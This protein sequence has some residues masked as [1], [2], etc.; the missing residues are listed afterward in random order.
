MNASFESA[1]DRNVLTMERM[2]AH[3]PGKVWRAVTET[4]H[5]AQWFPSRVEMD[6]RPG[7]EVRFDF[8]DGE[9]PESKGV[10]LEYDPPRALSFTWFEDT[11][12]FE[13][14]PDGDGCRLVLTHT[15]G[16]RAGAASFA[17]GWHVCLDALTT[18]LAGREVPADSP[19][20]ALHDDYLHRFGLDAG[21]VEETADGWRVRF[22]RQL[23]A[24][25]D[26][27]WQWLGAT[28]SDAP[29]VGGTPPRGAVIPEH[30]AGPVT[31]V[32]EQRLL[33]YPWLSDG[34]PAGTVRWEL[35][36]GTGH[37][38]RLFVTQTGSAEHADRAHV[39]LKS[40][41]D[42]IE[43]LAAALRQGQ[44]QVR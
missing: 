41:H 32:E 33:E 44:P 13:L 35:G 7:G 12:R 28:G 22:E 34:H 40:W 14:H 30:P 42:H 6:P 16:D 4:E 29:V 20:P 31:A 37:G 5:L 10:V 17:S 11:L 39:A 36:Q 26:E 19:S 18:V 21:M 3:P 2:L 43:R 25:A 8:P 9:G 38:P 23:T 24:P 15:F 1:G 27:V